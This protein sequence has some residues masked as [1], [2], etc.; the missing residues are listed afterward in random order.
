MG[1]ILKLYTE[2]KI[3][4]YNILIPSVCV[5]NLIEIRYHVVFWI[6]HFSS[7]L[8]N[9]RSLRSTNIPT[10]YL[11]WIYYN[12]VLFSNESI[13]LR[14]SPLYTNHSN[15]RTTSPRYIMVLTVINIL[16]CL[17]WYIR[18]SYNNTKQ[19]LLDDAVKYNTKSISS[20][21]I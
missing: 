1:N 11:W 16:L 21:V 18:Y 4:S 5:K 2:Q 14:L 6:H 17:M 9:L 12:C 15:T 19:W 20:I 8:N 13:K 10:W 7:F 3:F